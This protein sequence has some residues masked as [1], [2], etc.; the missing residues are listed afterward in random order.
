MCPP[1]GLAATH[2]GSCSSCCCQCQCLISANQQPL[3]PAAA[4]PHHPA[5]CRSAQPPRLLRPCPALRKVGAILLRADAL[6]LQLRDLDCHKDSQKLAPPACG[7]HSTLELFARVVSVYWIVGR[8]STACTLRPV[9]R[10]LQQPTDNQVADAPELML[11]G[12][13]DSLFRPLT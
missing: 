13:P 12:G 6:Q 8:S 10:D 5:A 11:P 7:S 9:L 2:S 4:P 1:P 3:Q